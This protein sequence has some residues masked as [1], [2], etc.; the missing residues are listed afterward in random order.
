[1]FKSKSLQ[2]T[3]PLDDYFV[4]SLEGRCRV[5]PPSLHWGNRFMD[6]ILCLCMFMCNVSIIVFDIL[7][8]SVPAV[9]TVLL[10]QH[11][12]HYDQYYCCA[13]GTWSVAVL[14]L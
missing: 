6:I 5:K 3:M 2:T 11:F 4:A 14:M 12:S 8:Y 1:M 10:S 7:F 13:V 9:L